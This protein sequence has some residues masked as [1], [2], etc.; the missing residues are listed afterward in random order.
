MNVVLPKPKVAVSGRDGR[1]REMLYVLSEA[2]GVADAVL[3]SVTHSVDRKAFQ[4]NAYRVKRSQEGPFTVTKYAD[5]MGMEG[6]RVLVAQ[7]PVGRYSAK[8]LEVF[9]AEAQTKFEALF[10]DEHSGLMSV[11]DDKF[12]ENS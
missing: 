6:G 11:F 1:G 3:V 2:G 4:A 12:K 5:L 7:K 10:A 9:A 8:A